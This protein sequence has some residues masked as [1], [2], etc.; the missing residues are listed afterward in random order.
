MVA[1]RAMK[2]APWAVAE[3]LAVAEVLELIAALELA[4]AEAAVVAPA[5]MPVA[6]VAA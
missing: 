2:T 3:L 5:R 1:V 4:L 6:D